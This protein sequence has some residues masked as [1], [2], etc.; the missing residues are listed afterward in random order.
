MSGV[1]LSKNNYQN[2][3]GRVIEMKNGPKKVDT[4]RVGAQMT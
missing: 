2:L 4:N 1:I 3:Q